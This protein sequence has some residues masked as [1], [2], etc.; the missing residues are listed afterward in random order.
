MRKRHLGFTLIELL[1]VISII[2]ILATLVIININGA[3]HRA[4]YTK[5]LTDMDTIV[6]AAKLY[7]A[8]TKSWPA[9][10]AKNTLPSEIASYL[11]TWPSSPCS[12]YVYKWDN[13]TDSTPT[14]YVAVTVR[15]SGS[16]YPTALEHIFYFYNVLNV[17]VLP[18]VFTG[19]TL[20]QKVASINPFYDNIQTTVGA[21]VKCP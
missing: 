13:V 6:D 8:E 17:D 10:V 19:S 5:T 18:K 20:N 12:K 2:G 11:P 21:T 4:N 7:Q 3:K 15:P 16:L 1:V 14:N 9:I